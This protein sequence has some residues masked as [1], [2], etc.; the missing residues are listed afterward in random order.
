MQKN[1]GLPGSLY[2]ALASLKLTLFLFFALA[3][4][5]LVGTLLPQGLAPEELKARYSPSIASWVDTLGLSDLYRAHWFQALL[6]LLCVNL[7]ACTVQRLP[8]TLK[9]L[10]QREDTFDSHKLLKFNLNHSFTAQLDRDDARPR[11]SNVINKEFAPL[12]WVDHPNAFCAVSEKGRWSRL[13]VYGVHLSVLMI[14]VGA[15]IGSLYG[16][17]GFMTIPEGTSSNEVTLFSDDRMA[18][19]PFDI[20][21]DKF[22]VTFYDTGAP[23]EFRSDL[24][25][26]DQGQEVLKSSIRVNDPLTYRGITFYQSSYGSMLRE[27]EV[28]FKDRESGKVHTL[29][30]PFRQTRDIPDSRDTVQITQFSRNFHQFGPALGIVVFREDHSPAGSMILAD[31]PE[32]HGNKVMNYQVKVLGIKQ[33]PYTGLQVKQD[34]GVWVVY[35]GFTLMILAV[36]VTFYASHR[37]IWVCAEEQRAGGVSS[38]IVVAGRTNKN[39]STFEEDF[40]RL[41]ERLEN[42]LTIHTARGRPDDQ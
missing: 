22:D 13:M 16:F 21:C 38:R 4:A 34:P 30:L 23:R 11:I 18:I 5:S 36:G 12:Q 8:K 9:I 20:R 2:D 14:L 17:K 33:V 1:R 3:G 24:V 7:I 32:F 40:N 28:E 31:K 26:V 15:L 25:I 27:A 35:L 6:V 39:T 19:L 10:K 29:V 37:K 41:C 42:E